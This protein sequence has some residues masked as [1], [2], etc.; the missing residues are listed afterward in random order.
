[1]IRHIGV[2]ESEY[3]VTADPLLTDPK[4]VMCFWSR[5]GLAN[6]HVVHFFDISDTD[7]SVASQAF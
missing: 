3:G 1:M 6:R 2:E 4:G 5:D 7:F